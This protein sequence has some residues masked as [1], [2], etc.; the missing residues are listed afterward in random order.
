[1]KIWCEL[2]GFPSDSSKYENRTKFRKFYVTV[3]AFRFIL[4][5][6]QLPVL[7]VSK[8]RHFTRQ[9]LREVKCT[10]LY[11]M[12]FYSVSVG[13]RAAVTIENAVCKFV[14]R[15]SS[16]RQKPYVTYLGDFWESKSVIVNVSG[17]RS[18]PIPSWQLYHCA[19]DIRAWRRRRVHASHVHK[20]LYWIW[21][22]HGLFAAWFICIFWTYVHQVETYLL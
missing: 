22:R 7:V 12:C 8:C 4:N 19:F 2:C 14:V 1:M 16:W 17:Y 9:H 6:S 21:V 13:W 10:A 20:R 3:I 11:Y 5:L 18:F 15:T